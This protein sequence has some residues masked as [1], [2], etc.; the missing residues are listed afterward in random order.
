MSSAGLPTLTPTIEPAPPDLPERPDAATL[1]GIVLSGALI[2]VMSALSAG[3]LSSGLYVRE[4]REWVGVVAFALLPGV[5]LVG[6]A[7]YW[8]RA[9]RSTS[10]ERARWIPL[11][12]PF[13]IVVGGSAGVAFVVA[14]YAA[15]HDDGRR[16][17][18]TEGS[19]EGGPHG[20]PR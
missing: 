17:P 6:A 7:R 9:L 14:A 5:I 11:L 1:V 16:L 3:A 10:R 12:L 13:F 4:P 2:F 8:W 19:S 20:A 15:S 18:Q